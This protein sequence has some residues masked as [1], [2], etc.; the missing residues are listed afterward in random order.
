MAEKLGGVMNMAINLGA[1]R[2]GCTKTN[3]PNGIRKV[4]RVKKAVRVRIP[5]DLCIVTLDFDQRLFRVLVSLYRD[6]RE[7]LRG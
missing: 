1:T 4:S 6:R 2:T 3:V 7:L 5:G